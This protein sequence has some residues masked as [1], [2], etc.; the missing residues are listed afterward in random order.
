MKTNFVTTSLTSFSEVKEFGFNN[1]PQLVRILSDNLYS[2]KIGSIIREIGSNCLD[3]HKLNNNESKPFEITVPDYNVFDKSKSNLIFR[4]FGPGLSK[5][6]IYSIYTTY[7]LLI[8][9][10]TKL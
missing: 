4:D 7:C 5:E 2:D 1:S 10:F 6:D 8:Y 3:A 9:L